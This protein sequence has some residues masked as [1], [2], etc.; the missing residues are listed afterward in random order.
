MAN[1][2]HKRAAKKS[3]FDVDA[4]YKK[5]PHVVHGSVREVP[6]DQVY[7]GVKSHGRMCEIKCQ[8]EKCGTKRT[9]NTQNAWETEYCEQHHKQV[10]LIKAAKRRKV[11]AKA[12]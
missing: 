1:N 10:M 7:D 3:G 6:A 2:K 12:A 9:I 4:F 11:R 5:Y 8:F